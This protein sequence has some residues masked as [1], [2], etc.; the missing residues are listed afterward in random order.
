MLRKLTSFHGK[1]P[2]VLLGWLCCMGTG[3]QQDRTGYTFLFRLHLITAS[4]WAKSNLQICLRFFCFVLFL[5]VLRFEFNTEAWIQGFALA[6]QA[7]YH[8]NHNCSLICS[9]CF[10]DSM[11]LFYPAQP[12]S[13]SFCFILPAIAG[14]TGTHHHAPFF[15]FLMESCKLFCSDCSGTGSSP[16]QHP[17]K[18]GLQA[19]PLAHDYVWVLI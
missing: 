7:L 1:I 18:Q 13:W 4:P 12:G 10:G 17:K 3:E 9:V 16:P 5:A 8:L 11:C 14:M 15:S 6:R 2:M 19:E